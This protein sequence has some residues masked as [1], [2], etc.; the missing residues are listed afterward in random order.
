MGNSRTAACGRRCRLGG[1]LGA[2]LALGLGSAWAAPVEV[3]LLHTNDLHSHFRPDRQ[4]PHLGG[5][6]RLKT[7]VEEIR[8]ER[9]AHVLLLDGG[10]WSEGS[11]Y[12]NL[13][14]GAE[15]L[16]MM[17]HV[18]YDVAVVGNHDWLNGPGQ[19]LRAVERAAPS[20]LTLLATNVDASPY[21]EAKAFVKR[22][23]PF[24]VR[25]IG[26]VKVGFVGIVTHEFIYDKFFAPVRILDEVDGIRAV[27]RRLRDRERC[28]VIVA[29]SHSTLGTNR[30]VLEDV[31][32]LDVIIGGHDH[33]KVFEPIVVRR[34]LG[35]PG[36]LVEAGSWGHYLGDLRLKLRTRRDVFRSGGRRVEVASY[37]LHQMDVRV[38]EHPETLARIARLE[39]LLEGQYGPVFRNEI[40]HSH[41]ELDRQGQES[42]MGNFVTDAYL[43]KAPEADFALDHINFIYNGVA[44]GPVR[45]VDVMNA[46]PAVFDPKTGKTWTLKTFEMRGRTLL[47]ALRLLF[48]ARRLLPDASYFDRSLLS[49]SGLNFVYRASAVNPRQEPLFTIEGAAGNGAARSNESLAAL[50][51]VVEDVRVRGEPLELERVY[52]VAASQGILETIEFINEFVPGTPLPV[53]P[54]SVRDTGVETWRVLSEY[55]A[56]RSPVTLEKVPTGRI[57]SETPDLGLA[58]DDIEVRILSERPVAKEPGRTLANARVRAR[59]RNFGH[60]ALPRGEARAQ[61]L[62]SENGLD[63]TRPDRFL[64]AGNLFVLPALAPDQETVVEWDA[65]FRG[66]FGYYPVTVRILSEGT[67]SNLSN[68]HVTRWIQGATSGLAPR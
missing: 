61:L 20:R 21:A 37:R 2:W 59:V 27:V 7:R 11:V 47:F 45:T 13:A 14:T 35:A 51:L 48:G 49:A 8:A 50:E 25:D 26:G 67:E 36:Y 64:E 3:T 19:L 52:R 65:S 41:I 38:P 4:L 33:E 1:I 44:R 23:P 58:I 28:D 40:G 17:D 6:A 18:G 24:A 10:D 46:I 63:L 12:Y 54:K 16:E 32:D 60:A 31:P 55:L 15:T 30:K 5:L 62:S 53:D 57:R 22:M 66:D 42:L 9:G 39:E 43:W 56:A 68:N 29:V 34:G